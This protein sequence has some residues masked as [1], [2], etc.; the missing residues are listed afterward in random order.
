[1][2][3]S[4]DTTVP[5]AHKV[6]ILYATTTGTARGQAEN[7]NYLLRNVQTSSKV[8]DINEYDEENLESEEYVMFLCS[9][10]L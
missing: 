6:T 8:I 10:W 7:L 4:I 5:I 2:E 3:N 9:T 1:M